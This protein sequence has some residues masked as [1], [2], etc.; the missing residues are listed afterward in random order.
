MFK[1]S[2]KETPKNPAKL[3]TK[4]GNETTV[5]L[6]G[7]V[8]LPAFWK[9]LP[10]EIF[11]LIALQTHIEIYEDISRNQL[12]IYSNGIAKCHPD[13]R[14][15]TILGER[16]AES[17]AKYNIYKLFYELTYKLS[18]YYGKILYGDSSIVDTPKE[19][20]MADVKKYDSLC[21]REKE[22]QIELLKGDKHE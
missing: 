6:K 19:G 5:L 20:L 17:R 11:E 22:H 16:M 13:D 1:V 14:Y 10:N 18:E 2:F 4:L 12:I 9:Y 7:T 15:D 21:K 3:V 8:E